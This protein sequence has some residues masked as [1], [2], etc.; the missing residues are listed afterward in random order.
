MGTDSICK[1]ISKHP[2]L[3][4]PG[5]YGTA[6]SVDI[7]NEKKYI[8]YLN[9][10]HNVFMW[11][12]HDVR[13]LFSGSIPIKYDRL[14]HPVR[15]PYDQA[16]ACYNSSL[17][18]SIIKNLNHPSIEAYMSD[19]GYF[20]FN[21]S[22]KYTKYY[23]FFDKVRIIEF[24]KLSNSFFIETMND[25]LSWIGVEPMP[26]NFDFHCD[27]KDID[28]F[29]EN[30]PL[31]IK[32]I[33]GEI[34]LFFIDKGRAISKNVYLIGEIID[35][36]FGDLVMYITVED[37]YINR[38]VISTIGLENFKKIIEDKMDEWSLLVLSQFEIFSEKKINHLPDSIIDSLNA[39][40]KNDYKNVL[41]QYPEI[42]N[43]WSDKW[44]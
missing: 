16:R 41:E 17:Q 10:T 28:Y 12:D 21:H 37:L 27:H 11:H 15:H 39:I 26:K 18:Q 24:S 3:Y 44:R 9:C 30:I 33:G 25:V 6:F 20:D 5:Y 19:M 14:L 4:C 7:Y 23:S 29:I 43:I 38:K 34:S 13:P 22:L 31:V 1:F 35:C 42:D 2:S 40:C 8:D 36:K 32:Y